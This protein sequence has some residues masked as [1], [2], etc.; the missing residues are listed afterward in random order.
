MF[1]KFLLQP[2]RVVDANMI[3]ETFGQDLI[4]IIV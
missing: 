4:Q 1:V 2:L 3:P